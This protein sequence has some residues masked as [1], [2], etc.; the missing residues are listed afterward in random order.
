MRGMCVS[1][2][3]SSEIDVYTYYHNS[4]DY[5]PVSQKQPHHHYCLGII[6]Y[7]ICCLKFKVHPSNIDPSL[8]V[9]AGD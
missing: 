1:H 6:F 4:T 8:Q 2:H 9:G 7:F 5:V 3:F